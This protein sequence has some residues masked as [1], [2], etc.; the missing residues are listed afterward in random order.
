MA[1]LPDSLT[2]ELNCLYPRYVCSVS[3]D[4][5][6]ANGGFWKGFATYEAM[7]AWLKR[8]GYAMV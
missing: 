8:H 5:G 3:D 7:W 4:K 2:V 6:T 1:R